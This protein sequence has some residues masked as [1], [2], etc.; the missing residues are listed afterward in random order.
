M[1]NKMNKLTPIN[2]AEFNEKCS[3]LSMPDAIEIFTER[4]KPVSARNKSIY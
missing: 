2:W 4:L 1:E 3:G